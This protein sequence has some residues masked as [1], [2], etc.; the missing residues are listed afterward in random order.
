MMTKYAYTFIND[1]LNLEMIRV[2]SSWSGVGL[3]FYLY[4]LLL[5]TV[6]YVQL[7]ISAIFNNRLKCVAY[8]L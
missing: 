2:L 5:A 7:K 6:R 3:C 4:R 8:S 1:A